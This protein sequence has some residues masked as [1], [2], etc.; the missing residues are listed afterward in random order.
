MQ[1]TARGYL[2]DAENTS[3]LGWLEFLPGHEHQQFA[4]L[5]RHAIERLQGGTGICS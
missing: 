5:L 1:P 2:G 4:V 3:D